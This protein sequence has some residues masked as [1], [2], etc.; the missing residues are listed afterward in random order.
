MMETCEVM[1]KNSHMLDII[2]LTVKL[3]HNNS[4]AN[5]SIQKKFQE[6][7]LLENENYG[8]FFRLLRW[9]IF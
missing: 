7:F 1:Y 2:N 5:I 4:L 8:I 6:A 3:L 9:L